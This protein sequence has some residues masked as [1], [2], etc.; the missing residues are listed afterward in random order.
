MNALQQRFDTNVDN[1]FGVCFLRFS[2]VEVQ[3][4]LTAYKLYEKQVR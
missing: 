4:F 2:H 1:Y 3:Y